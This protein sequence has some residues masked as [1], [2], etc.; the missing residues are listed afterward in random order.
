MPTLPAPGQ[1]P[2]FPYAIAN[3][4]GL[5]L[6]SCYRCPGGACYSGSTTGYTDC[7]CSTQCST[8]IY[9]GAQLN[10]LKKLHSSGGMPATVRVR[11]RLVDMDKKVLADFPV[12]VLTPFG[13]R[14]KT[15]T[16][17]KGEFK[18]DIEFVSSAAQ[19]GPSTSANLGVLV[20]AR[21]HKIGFTMSLGFVI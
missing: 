2:K 16:D 12:Y 8:G 3:A 19:K 13:L 15:N 4:G 21:D 11:G 9:D 10:G 5:H 6:L 17:A 18:M 7:T 1:K 14:L 20:S